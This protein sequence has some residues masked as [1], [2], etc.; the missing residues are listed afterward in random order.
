MNAQEI[1]DKVATHL[2]TQKARSTSKP[3]NA[4][5][6]RGTFGR[7]CAVG[8]LI[9]DDVYTDEMEGASAPSIV[10]SYEGLKHFLP[11]MYL[12]DALQEVHD[13]KPINVWRDH[14]EQ[15]ANDFNLNTIVLDQNYPS[16][17]KV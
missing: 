7:M 11:H 15:I 4:C 16:P 5:A 12:L 9:P 8:V 17:S 1:F 6:Y 10:Q 13:V 14:L 3:F 2:L